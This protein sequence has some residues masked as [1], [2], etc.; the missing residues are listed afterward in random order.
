MFS[1]KPALHNSGGI[2]KHN[3]HLTYRV[4]EAH[5]VLTQSEGLLWREQV[6]REWTFPF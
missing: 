3:C 1:E 2:K 5:A 6:R 4:P